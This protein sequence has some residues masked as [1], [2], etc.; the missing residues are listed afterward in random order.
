MYKT[1]LFHCV[2][3]DKIL[4]IRIA[5]TEIHLGDFFLN[6]TKMIAPDTEIFQG[7]FDTNINLTPSNFH[8]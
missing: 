5:C 2:I 1:M 6:L 7:M 4:K 3:N 8:E